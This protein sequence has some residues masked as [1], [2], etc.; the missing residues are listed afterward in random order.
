MFNADDWS[1][2][3]IP[4]VTRARP[5]GRSI[6]KVSD[7]YA[8]FTLADYFSFTRLFW[9]HTSNRSY[10]V[11]LQMLLIFS[12][13]YVIIGFDGKFNMKSSIFWLQLARLMIIAHKC[14]KFNHKLDF[15]SS[16]K[17]NWVCEVSPQIFQSEWIKV[18]WTKHK[19][20]ISL[21]G[22]LTGKHSWKYILT[23]I[24]SEIYFPSSF[25]EFIVT[26]LFPIQMKIGRL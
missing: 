21:L 17:P 11:Y 10:I 9:L 8:K 3:I 25:I 14:L 15:Y 16:L 18:L 23:T 2:Q 4:A 12:L 1:R 20:C 6:N 26:H 13:I 24:F 7:I 5:L 22:C 19:Y